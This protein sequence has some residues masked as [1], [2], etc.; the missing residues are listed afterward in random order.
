MNNF[1][2]NRNDLLVKT[3]YL[4]LTIGFILCLGNITGFIAMNIAIAKETSLNAIYWQRLFV[5][6][7]THMFIVPGLWIMLASEIILTWKLYGLF[8]NKW[9][10][11]ILVLIIII[12]TNGIFNILPLSDKVT[13]LSTH[14]MQIKSMLP[15]YLALKN[16]EDLFGMLNFVML[17]CSLTIR[18]YKPYDEQLSKVFTSSKL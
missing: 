10:N 11:I 18:I 15:E 5:T 8:R 3:A 12:F 13:S 16:K 9:S 4:F 6:K 17:L 14:Q 1:T 2:R 7:I